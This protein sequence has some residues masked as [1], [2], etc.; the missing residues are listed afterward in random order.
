MSSAEG[1]RLLWWLGA[2]CALPLFLV[3]A[4]VIW[5]VLAVVVRVVFIFKG[6]GRNFGLGGGAFE[7]GDFEFEEGDAF[8]ELADELHQSVNDGEQ[9]TDQR[10]LIV[11]PQG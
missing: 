10:R 9:L 4:V 7:D 2:A 1:W 8:L 6:T 5:V 11:M 3:L